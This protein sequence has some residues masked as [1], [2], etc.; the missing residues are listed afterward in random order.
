MDVF[1][2]LIAKLIPIYV[3]IGLGYALTKRYKID[4]DSIVKLSIYLVA[5]V[6]IFHGVYTLDLSGKVLFLPLL[7]F[8]VST[9]L[10]DSYPL[11]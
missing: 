6:V 8:M 1:F 4:K 11:R 2:T 5:P 3:L 10:V 7:F 9:A